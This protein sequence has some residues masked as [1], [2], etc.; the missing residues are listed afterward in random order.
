M[1]DFFIILYKSNKIVQFGWKLIFSLQ[2]FHI[3]VLFKSSEAVKVFWS[4]IRPNDEYLLK[5]ISCH[6]IFFQG[7]YTLL[8]ESRGSSSRSPIIL[9]KPSSP[10]SVKKNNIYG[11]TLNWKP[12][13][14]RLRYSMDIGSWGFTLKS[15]CPCEFHAAWYKPRLVYTIHTYSYTCILRSHPLAKRSHEIEL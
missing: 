15:F 4:Y 8:E 6:H 5:N 1:S 3:W 14:K 10:S 13:Y 9:T 7:S 12:K 11:N 2:G